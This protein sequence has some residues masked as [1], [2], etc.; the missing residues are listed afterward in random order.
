M[1]FTARIIASSLSDSVSSSVSSRSKITAF[2]LHQGVG[3]GV[4]VLLDV[5]G[6]PLVQQ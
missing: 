4:L 2:I 3:V 1:A 6:A 5:V